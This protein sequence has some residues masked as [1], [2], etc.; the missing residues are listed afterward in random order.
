[1]PVNKIAVLTSG[2]DAPG[3]NACIRAICLACE[4]EGIEV[5]GYTHGYNGLL[6]Q[7]WRT[8]ERADVYNLIQRGGT[9]LYSARCDKFKAKEGAELAAKNLDELNVDALIVIGGNG[10]FMGLEHLQTVWDKPVVGIPGTIDNDISGTD[11]TI[12][13]HTA[14]QTAVESIDKV[15]DTAEAFERIF[16][17]EVM[18]REA[19]FI[20][21]DSAISSGSDHVLVP[22]LFTS[23]AE[24]LVKILD[25]LEVRRKNKT[26]PSHII[27]ITENLWPGGL[28]VLADSL[29]S[30]TGFDLRVLTLG[31][32]QRGGSPVSKD[33]ML[34]TRLGAFAVES[35]LNG[36]RGVMVGET[37]TKPVLV[38]LEQTRTTTKNLNRYSVEILDRI[39]R[40]G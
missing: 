29:A 30:E 35:L 19:G 15:R 10:S 40:L 25:K 17:V 34:A 31:H 4:H 13:F 23:A 1:M 38:P 7:D 8:L 14:I 6:R 26:N 18:G 12:G 5:I 9:I 16:L 36:A 24:E 33:R 3:M 32:V 27:I 20:A 21:L 22:E 37:H 11:F 28:Q 2:G 39:T